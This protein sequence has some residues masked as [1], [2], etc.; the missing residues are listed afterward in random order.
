LLLLL[1]LLV[2]SLLTWTNHGYHP[3]WCRPR[4][5][6]WRWRWRWLC[7]PPAAACPHECG[8]CLP[9]R[10]VLQLCMFACLM[11]SAD[12]TCCMPSLCASMHAA[13]L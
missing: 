10:W 5:S 12:H 7:G 9:C 4:H 6:C 8:G 2:P 13:T 11:A 3:P 1:L